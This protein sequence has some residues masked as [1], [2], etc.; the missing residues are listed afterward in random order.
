MAKKKQA[1]KRKTAKKTVKKAKKGIKQEAY[2]FKRLG[3]ETYDV[4]KGE[5]K[6]KAKQSE[7]WVKKNPG[8]SVAIAAGVG[9]IL[10]KI[11]GRR[12]R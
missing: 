8:K 11:F 6:E 9:F 12:K 4:V 1:V 3:V 10:A 7:Q 5:V 2:E